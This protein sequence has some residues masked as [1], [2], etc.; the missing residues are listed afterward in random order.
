VATLI[1]RSRARG[2]PPDVLVVEDDTVIREQLAEA[3]ADEGFTVKTAA[4][5][6]EALE[7]LRRA[8]TGVV[9]ADLMMPVMSGW[10][11]IKA[12][13][14][15]PALA[16]VPVMI[17]TA[18]SNVGRAPDGPVFLKPL[19]LDSLIRAIRTHLGRRH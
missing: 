17:M 6:R 3:L 8:R 15:S 12:M 19:N 16:D 11:L 13:R 18:A 4:D 5:G 9:V 2:A 14:S 7:S 1:D 10:D